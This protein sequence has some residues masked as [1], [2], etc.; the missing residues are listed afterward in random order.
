MVTAVS[1]REF[2]FF[3]RADGAD[4]GR[5]KVLGPLAHNQADTARSSVYQDRIPGLHRVGTA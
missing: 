4:D 2:G 1:A 5:A 3:V